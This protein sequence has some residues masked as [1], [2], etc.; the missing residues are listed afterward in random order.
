LR[1]RIHDERPWRGI[2]RLAYNEEE[3]YLIDAESPEAVAGSAEGFGLGTPPSENSVSDI[4]WSS[5]WKLCALY[6]VM[7]C[8]FLQVML[9][10]YSSHLKYLYLMW[11]HLEDP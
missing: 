5:S 7:I 9:I 3:M 8:A 2:L 1:W 6:Y 11:F 10:P 4:W